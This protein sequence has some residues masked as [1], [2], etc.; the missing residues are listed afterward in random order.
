MKIKLVELLVACQHSGWFAIG[1]HAWSRENNSFKL[2][3][4]YILGRP[5][6]LGLYWIFV[7]KRSAGFVCSHVQCAQR[8]AELQ[9]Y[10]CS[11]YHLPLVQRM[12]NVGWPGSVLIIRSS[13]NWS[14]FSKYSVAHTWKCKLLGMYLGHG[15]ASGQLEQ[16][17]DPFPSVLVFSQQTL[18]LIYH[19]LF[20][21]LWFSTYSISS[22]HV[23]K[24]CIPAESI[25][26]CRNDGG[27]FL[28][29]SVSGINQSIDSD[30]CCFLATLPCISLLNCI[31]HIFNPMT[32]TYNN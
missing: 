22:A 24:I 9:W 20:Q 17:Y 3:L 29:T 7:Q 23:L 4:L 27:L 11:M 28:N 16:P 31:W 10:L 30:F 26:S 14:S 15:C 6:C 21:W 1:L 2:W 12:K 18:Q 13:G 19:Q 5:E 32:I 25:C 8:M